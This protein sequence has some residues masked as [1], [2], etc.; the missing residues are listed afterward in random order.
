LLSILSD[1]DVSIGVI[2]YEA[3]IAYARFFFLPFGVI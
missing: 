1:P 2:E 3:T